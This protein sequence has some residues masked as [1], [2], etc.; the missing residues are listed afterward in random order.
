MNR[1]IIL[2]ILGLFVLIVFSGTILYL[3][4]EYRYEVLQT[5]E[6][7]QTP[8]ILTNSYTIEPFAVGLPFPYHLTVLDDDVFFNQRF[9]G[10]LFVIKNEEFQ[11]NPILNFDSENL[12]T[13]ILG[14]S[15]DDSSIFV[16]IAESK[17]NKIFE[18]NRVLKYSW[19]GN[20]LNF[21]GEVDT[22]ALYTDEHHSGDSLVMDNEKI[23]STIPTSVQSNDDEYY[24]YGIHGFDYDSITETIWH[25]SEVEWPENLEEINS[26]DQY[27][28]IHMM[29]KPYKTSKS[30]E[31]PYYPNSLLIP[32]V[33]L[34][35]NY[36]DSL[37][38]GFCKGVNAGG[39][40]LYEY[41]LNSERNEFLI[42]NT[43][44]TL[45]NVNH[46]KFLIGENFYCVSDMELGSDNII[47]LTDYVSNGAIYK[48]A[49]KQ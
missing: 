21:I 25:T 32:E 23:I 34:S 18:N 46:E 2:P 38:V 11:K 49:P 7:K 29:H 41:P 8:K 48:I 35:T 15:S 14:I 27:E 36:N 5:I 47:Y 12:Y 6:I 16:H 26:L 30:W 39:G 33:N 9:T 13:R 10:K 20:S 42:P 44:S 3:D 43:Q 40:G 1:K 28:K 37:F 17:E 31:V 22:L 19:D 45:L 24:I 4:S